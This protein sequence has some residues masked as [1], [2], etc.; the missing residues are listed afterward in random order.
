M[1]SEFEVVQIALLAVIICVFWLIMGLEDQKSLARLKKINKE[2]ES[3]IRE[4]FSLEE[5][6]GQSSNFKQTFTLWLCPVF[7]LLL[8]LVL[9]IFM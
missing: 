9:L 6:I 3:K 5:E 1:L 7:F 8:W 2:L 4:D